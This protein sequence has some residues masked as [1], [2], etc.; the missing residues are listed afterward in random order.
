LSI[1]VESSGD[2][3]RAEYGVIPVPVTDEADGTAEP[4]L[5]ADVAIATTAAS[6]VNCSL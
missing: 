1:E 5:Q 3:P 2:A 4:P 6:A